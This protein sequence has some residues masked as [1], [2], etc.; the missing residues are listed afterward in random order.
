MAGEMNYV[1]KRASLLLSHSL[2]VCHIL[3]QHTVTQRQDEVTNELNRNSS[4]VT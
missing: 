3:K 4:H 2:R 1:E